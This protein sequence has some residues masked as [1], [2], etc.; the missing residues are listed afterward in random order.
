MV[1]SRSM[2]PPSLLIL[3]TSTLSLFAFPAPAHACRAKGYTSSARYNE[4]FRVACHNCYEKQHGFARFYNVFN[5][6]KSVEIDFYDSKAIGTG[7]G[8]RSRHWYVR[9]MPTGSNKSNCSGS[10]NLERCLRDI[11]KWSTDHPGHE[12]ITAFLDKKQAW[13]SSGNGRTPADLDRLILKVF[14]ARS[15]FRPKDLKGRHKSLRAAARAGGWPTMR[16]LRGKVIFV[17]NGGKT[18]N[19]NQ[20]QHRYVRSRKGRAVLFV[21]P[22]TDEQKDITGTP[23]QFTRATARYVVFYNIKNGNEKWGSTIRRYNYV[24]RVWGGDAKSNNTFV[25]VCVNFV[26]RYKFRTHRNRRSVL[27]RPTVR[28][29]STSR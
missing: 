20:T 8:G 2:K 13:G 22:D 27:A 21:G 9:H 6:T 7:A 26:A 3:A 14:P 5:H 10:G 16:Q 11:R 17:L 1:L 23:N 12:V 18:F 25:Q 19:H 29:L 4:V 15:L 24:S 28:P